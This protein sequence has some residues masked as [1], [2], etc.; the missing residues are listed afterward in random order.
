MEGKTFS[1]VG[2]EEGRERKLNFK[3]LKWKTT[4]PIVWEW[5]ERERERE[6]GGTS[7]GRALCRCG[8]RGEFSSPLVGMG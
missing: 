7:G 8:G 3:K 5:R 6:E 1:I 4:F 2:W